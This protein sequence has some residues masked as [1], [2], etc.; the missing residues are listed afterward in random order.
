MSKIVQEKITCPKQVEKVLRLIVGPGPEITVN[1]KK[2]SACST[3]QIEN[4]R[5]ALGEKFLVLG[6]SGYSFQ[7]Y[8]NLTPKLVKKVRVSG[9]LGDVVVFKVF[10]DSEY[11]AI[12]DFENRLDDVVKVDF[13]EEEKESD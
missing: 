10:K 8:G 11:S 13:E 7:I 12:T 1:T 2:E 5:I 3:E 9:K 6:V 4:V